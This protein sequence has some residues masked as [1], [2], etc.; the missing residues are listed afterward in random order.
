[1]NTGALSTLTPLHDDDVPMESIEQKTDKAL[2]YD[3]L[4]RELQLDYE[5]ATATDRVKSDAVC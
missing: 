3:I 4:V 5:R 1:M 2:N